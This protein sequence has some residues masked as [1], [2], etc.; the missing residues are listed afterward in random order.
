MVFVNTPLQRG[1][2][3]ACGCQNRFNGFHTPSATVKTVGGPLAARAALPKQGMNEIG[4]ALVPRVSNPL[5]WII[6]N[7]P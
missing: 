2:A 1:G 7:C 4:A 6:L 5:R 3:L